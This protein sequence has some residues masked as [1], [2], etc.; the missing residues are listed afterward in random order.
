LVSKQE[1]VKDHSEDCRFNCVRYYRQAVQFRRAIFGLYD[2]QDYINWAQAIALLI[3]FHIDVRN[4]VLKLL[5]GTR[6]ISLY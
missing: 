5:D 6:K 1:R 3:A 4:G 2:R